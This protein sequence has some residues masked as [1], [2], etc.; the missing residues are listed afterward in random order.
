MKLERKTIIGLIFF[1]CLIGFTYFQVTSLRV[2]NNN[3]IFKN[4]L[5]SLGYSVEIMGIPLNNLLLKQITTNSEK[6]YSLKDGNYLLMI[7]S[8]SGC[9]TCLWQELEK[10]KINSSTFKNG[11]QIKYIYHGDNMIDALRFNKFLLKSDTIYTSTD[12]KLKELN[13][14][15]KFPVLFYIKNGVVTDCHFPVPGDTL[16]SNLFYQR[17]TKKI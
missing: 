3:D 8:T 9:S 1:I 16:F 12:L 5:N 10:M 17:V 4:R 15:G 11:M 7:L 13:P 14:S 6:N 2:T